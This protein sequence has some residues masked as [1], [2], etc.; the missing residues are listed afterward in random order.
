[1]RMANRFPLVLDTT[2]NNKI[3]EIQTGDNLNLADNS[4]VGVQNIT[5][6]GTINAA[7]IKVNGNR[8]VAQAF[9][10]LTDTPST[11]VGS[12]NYFVKVK[13]DGTGLEYRPLSD[14]GN[15]EID[16]I[17]VDTSIVPT[18]DG[19]GNVGTEDKKFN[20]IVAATLKGNLVSFNEEIVFDAT[21]GRI[22]YA[23][24]QGVPT[25]LSEFTDD[26]GFLKTT[27]LD[28]Q[29]AGLFDEGQQFVTDIQGSVFGDDSTLLVDGVN[30]IITGDVENI[31]VDTAQL[32]AT[33]I[34]STAITAQLFE[35]PPAGD[36]Q[37]DAGV[38]GII[39]IGTGVS[40]TAVNIENA[41]IETFDQGSGLGV[42]QLTANT[43]LAITAGNRVRIEGGVPFRVSSTT[44]AL[45]LAIGAQEGDVIYNTTTSRLQMYQGGAWK[46]VNGNVEATTGTSNFNDVVIAGNLTVTGTTTN[47]ETTNTTITDNIIVLN[48]GEIGAGVTA[49]TSGI[50]IDRGSES[51]KTFVWDDSVD[52]WTVG[53]E[54]LVAATFEGDLTGDV[55]ATDIE[56]DGALG[57]LTFDSLTAPEIRNGDGSVRVILFG[58][59]YS[60]GAAQLYVEANDVWLYSDLLVEQNAIVKGDLKAAA[61]KGTF[62]GDDSA[63]LV[64]GVAGKIT[65]DV[66]NTEV[67]T[68]TVQGRASA[69]LN[70]YRG[71]SGTVSLGDSS[72]GDVTVSDSGI[73]ITS[74]AG[75]DINGAAGGTVDVGTSATTGNV[76]IGKAG[77]TTTVDGT[78][79]A[80]LTGD[81]TGDVTGNVTGNIDNTTLDIGRTT[82]TAI[83][84]GRDGASTTT[85]YGDLKLDQALIVNNL[86]ADDSIIITTADGNDNAITLSPGGTNTIV[87]LQADSILFNGPVT[88]ELIAQGGVTGDL[89]GSVFA[90]DSTILVD[91]VNGV[92]PYGVLDGAPTALSDLSNDLDYGTLV[93]DVIALNGLPV[94][95]F[96]TGDLDAQNNNIENA[97]LVNATGNLTGDIVG[98]VFADDSAVM[99][100]AVGF[101]MF[102][103]TLSLTPL[104]AEPSNPTNGMIAVADGTGWDPASNAKNTLVAYL[105]GAWVTVAAAA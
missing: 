62:V 36:M 14:L 34:T 68:T 15:I 41:I 99:V 77:N 73:N 18:T 89:K 104:N 61:F 46:D 102:S 50:E 45:Q 12:P 66:E 97:N 75:V 51:N 86:T 42:A 70:I 95:T 93:G 59:D 64:D 91:A 48:N 29:L 60:P 43:D 105:G 32:T 94:D 11:F 10:D 85:I 5:A 76:T 31:Y 83:N 65:G 53:S 82:A 88:S 96:M 69:A 37:I 44:A 101:A 20:E 39:N 55:V 33:Q 79:N 3:K 54:T 23:A 35:G 98:S 19:V 16:T 58:E 67:I 28:D 74:T 78:F 103:D 49:T 47:V 1:M 7:D 80:T 52:K 30:G 17:T 26:V 40:T 22:S 87:R 27:D 2:D 81:V 100:D 84:I 56:I 38:T 57:R 6:L 72:S 13:A 8:L 4:I 9:N 71:A 63:V 24:L 92:I 25:F 21:T 90:D